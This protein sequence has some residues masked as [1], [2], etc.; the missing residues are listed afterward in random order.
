MT[1]NYCRSGLSVEKYPQF[2]GVFSNFS[3]YL[4]IKNFCKQQM[5]AYDE[6][7]RWNVFLKFFEKIWKNLKI[8]ENF[9]NFLKRLNN[10]LQWENCKKWCVSKKIFSLTREGGGEDP[11]TPWNSK[12]SAPLAREKGRYQKSRFF[13]I[14]RTVNFAFFLRL[15]QKM[16]VIVRFHQN[17][18]EESMQNMLKHVKKLEKSKFFYTQRWPAII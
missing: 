4:V 18:R 10:F 6:K 1:C 12:I 17:Y 14:F 11:C 5:I 2:R 9:K 3:V 13:L 8:L 16:S 7:F 15:S